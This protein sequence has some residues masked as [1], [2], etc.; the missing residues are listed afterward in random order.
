MKTKRIIS[1]T[2]FAVALVLTGILGLSKVFENGWQNE[3]TIDNSLDAEI[4]ENNDGIFDYKYTNIALFKEDRTDIEY[5]LDII[6]E[7]H[8]ENVEEYIQKSGI[9]DTPV[10]ITYQ[11]AANIAGETIKYAI[12]FTDHQNNV[13]FVERIPMKKSVYKYTDLIEE[14]EE[15]CVEMLD[16]YECYFI[17]YYEEVLTSTAPFNEEHIEISVY[18]D[19]QTGKVWD[20][21]VHDYRDDE[22]VD[23]GFTA[24]SI[25][26]YRG[27]PS[28][29]KER[30]LSDVENILDLCDPG[31]SINR[32]SIEE[33]DSCYMAYVETADSLSCMSFEKGNNN[34]L[35][36]Y[37]SRVSQV[38]SPY[39]LRSFEKY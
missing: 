33:T 16:V 14:A 4:V 12:G 29:L 35:I 17:V 7:N 30:L 20:I 1:L 8:I 6:I 36:S 31:K 23:T 24:E 13:A 25:I 26:D 9:N 15:L 39:Y 18:I 11:Q 10:T 19:A 22:E 37:N 3:N 32:Y 27:V 21:Y 38:V 34:Q 28:P 2:V 5:P